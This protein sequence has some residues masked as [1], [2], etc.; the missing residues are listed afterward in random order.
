M[1]FGDALQP[2]DDLDAT[3]W[4]DETCTGDFGTVGCLVP[5]HFES[6]VRVH[7]PQEGERW[8]ENYQAL[9]AAVAEVGA[10]HTSTPDH[11]YVGLWEGYGWEGGMTLRYVPPTKNPIERA[12]QMAEQRRLRLESERQAA[13]MR[14]KLERLPAFRRPSRRYFLLSGTVADVTRL[15]E[16]THD[17]WH[18]PD[19]WWPADQ[20]W[21]VASDVD[22]WSLY[23]GGTQALVDD[24]RATV[25]TLVEDVALTDGFE[26]ED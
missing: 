6:T 4:L 20:A 8:R 18:E 23:V 9:F 7:P 1:I 17:R 22:F 15:R 14:A 21:S 26:I 2:S 25:P 10:R 11:A 16:P 5:S 13:E 12:K 24:L 3:R 19:L